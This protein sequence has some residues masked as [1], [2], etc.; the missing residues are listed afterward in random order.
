MAQGNE[1][2]TDL[3]K[4]VFDHTCSLHMFHYEDEDL[5]KRV[6]EKWMQEA[7]RKEVKAGDMIDALKGDSKAKA[8]CRALV[9]EITEDQTEDTLYLKFENESSTYDRTVGRWSSDIAPL[10]TYSPE[11][12]WKL[13]L[14][15]G[16]EVDALD[17]A[18]AWYPST[19]LA[20]KE[21]TI[22]EWKFFNVEIGFR[23]YSEN[24]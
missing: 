7:W 22:G 3:M 20:I 17:K 1:T 24:G 18:K 21:Q 11:N 2:L 23:I 15:V 8:W 4:Y 12:D 10:N 14:K 13:D 19:I 5:E 6:K 9:D 16:D